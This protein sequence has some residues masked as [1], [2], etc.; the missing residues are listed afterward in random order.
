MATGSVRARQKLPGGKE[1]DDAMMKLFGHKDVTKLSDYEIARVER[2]LGKIAKPVPRDTVGSKKPPVSPAS[3]TS[4]PR[5]PE[6]GYRSRAADLSAKAFGPVGPDDPDRGHSRV[7]STVDADE[8]KTIRDGTRVGTAAGRSG[9]TW[10]YDSPPPEGVPR[11]TN[12]PGDRMGEKT[13]KNINPDTKTSGDRMRESMAGP[14]NPDRAAQEHVDQRDGTGY[15]SAKKREANAERTGRGARKMVD[16]GVD[17]V[18]DAAAKTK[19]FI[20][21]EGFDRFRQGAAS[22]YDKAK[23]FARAHPLISTG[24]AG[25]AGVGLLAALLDGDDEYRGSRM[26]LPELASDEEI[27]AAFEREVMSG[28]WDPET[29]GGLEEFS[30]MVIGW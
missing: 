19:G 27:A 24:V 2:E 7:G 30:R 11:A 9:T 29:D 15:N 25:I 22:L 3:R 6:S 8:G 18:K 4:Q 23:G 12:V 17:K 26:A 28:R 20:A 13:F 1:T 5:V 10:H 21:G 14:K 16:E